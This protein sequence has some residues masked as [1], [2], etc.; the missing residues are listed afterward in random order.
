VRITGT[1]TALVSPVLEDFSL[2]RAGLERNIGFQ[3]QQGVTG[4]VPTGTTGESPTLDWK[5]HNEVI[6]IVLD[7]CKGRLGV[8]AGTGSNST[9]ETV[10]NTIRAAYNGAQ[11][12]LLVDCYYNGPSTQELRDEY[13]G[14]VASRFPEMIVVPYVIPGRSGTSL[15]VEDLAILAQQYP[16]VSAVKEATGNLE[17]MA[18]TR[19]LLGD[20]FSIISG[21]DDLTY[22]MMTRS[23]IRA[24]GAISVMSNVIPGAISKMVKSIDDGDLATAEK[25]RDAAAPL[26]GIVT[27]TVEN[28]RT[29]PN[30]NVVKVADRYRNP[31]AVK[32][33]MQGLGMSAGA[34]RRP[35]GRMTAAGVKVVR[36][37]VKQV[38]Q[39]NP[40]ILAPISDFYG[41]DVEARINDNSVWSRFAL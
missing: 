28:D 40:E 21:D 25:L 34:C 39:N 27:V 9:A 12:V 5:E 8:L 16:N 7:N 26:L 38:W 4:V 31:V 1:W 30:G 22:T 15:S 19:S 17:R 36:D 33:L 13:Y 41:V 29:L 10:E 35:L 2:D 14:V 23:D 6:D 3:I 37:A 18:Y 11:G 24:N 32:T 20:E